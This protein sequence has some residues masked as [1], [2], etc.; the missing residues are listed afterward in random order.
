MSKRPPESTA[1]QFRT[2]RAGSFRTAYI[3]AGRPELPTVV[4]LHEGAYGA[5]AWLCWRELIGALAE[6]YH[7]VAPDLLGFGETDKA[8]FLDRSPYS[9]RV[10]HISDF[11]RTLG[12]GDAAFIGASFGGSLAL[13]AVAQ[14]PG[15][16][17]VSRVLTLSGSGGPY[18]L[19]SGIE[20]LA[21][22]DSTLEAAR[23]ITS[24]VV[25]N[26]DD[27]EDHI[28]TRLE[29]SLMPGH[30]EA[31]NAPRLRAPNRQSPPRED[32]FLGDLGS[33]SVPVWFVEGKRDRLLETGWSERLRELTPGSRSLLGDFAHE[34]NIDEPEKLL[35]ILRDFLSA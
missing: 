34:P 2:V 3:E 13:R 16:W 24:L 5:S 15:A 17:P 32:T 20:A 7:V 1:A 8:V 25:S 31:Q 11:C 22:F 23:K 6:D 19:P 29:L 33:V 14:S 12:I 27:L 18:R 28:E 9:F 10:D 26:V 4:L 35:P 21:D 30:W